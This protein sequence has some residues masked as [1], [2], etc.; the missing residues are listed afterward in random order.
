M[1]TIAKYFFIGI[2]LFACFAIFTK[3]NFKTNRMDGYS[4]DR[5]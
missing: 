5:L 2:L 1:K 4:Y 3:K